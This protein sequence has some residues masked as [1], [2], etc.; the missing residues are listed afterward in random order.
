MWNENASLELLKSMP[1]ELTYEELERIQ[2]LLDADKYVSSVENGRDMCGEFAPFCKNCD[3]SG[4]TPCAV[5]YIRMKIGE[6]ANYK[7]VSGE[8]KSENTETVPGEQTCDTSS[9]EDKVVSEEVSDT[10]EE[11]TSEN[12]ES[13]STV[14]AEQAAMADLTASQNVPRLDK[15]QEVLRIDKPEEVLKIDKPEEV[16]K[17][18]GE[19][20]TSQTETEAPKSKKIRIAIARRKKVQ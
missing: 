17:I 13:S 11:G 7:I 15:P 5:S 3:K 2:R 4:L 20:T 1:E 6:G 14:S 16:L 12:V 8:E 18:E 19:S 9:D 10:N